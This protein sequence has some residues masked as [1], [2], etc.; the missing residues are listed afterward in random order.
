V[1]PG[2]HPNKV[3]GATLT[4]KASLLGGEE[5]FR[6]INLSVRFSF[7]SFSKEGFQVPVF[8]L[9]KSLAKWK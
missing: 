2:L 6:P 5:R 3:R 9:L 4:K 1:F 7:A 8:T